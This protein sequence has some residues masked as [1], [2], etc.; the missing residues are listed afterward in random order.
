M[1]MQ[2]VNAPTVKQPK[3][4]VWTNAKIYGNH[5]FISGMTAHDLEGNAVGGDSMYEQAKETFRKIKALTEAAGAR[6]DDIIELS[7]YV[8]N[9]SEREGVWQARREFFT[10]DFPC[11][12]LVEVKGLA[13]P[14]LKVEIKAQGYV[15][16]AGTEA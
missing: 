12:T 6:M 13:I 14:A 2:S 11:C 8:T 7:I 15:G 5:F 4:G 10:G 9:M 1:K 16:A 3:P